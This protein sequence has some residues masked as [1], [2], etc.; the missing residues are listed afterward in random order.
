MSSKKNIDRLFQEK[1]KDFE[2]AP[3]NTVWERIKTQQQKK[4]RR[5]L[6]I[7]FWYKVVGIA[8]AVA[9][10]FTMM[11]SWSDNEQEIEIV[12]TTKNNLIENTSFR[13][14]NEDQKKNPLDERNV[15]DTVQYTHHNLEENKVK[16]DPENSSD[17]DIH[18]HPSKTKNIN[19]A[20][21]T[22]PH[23]NNQIPDTTLKHQSDYIH[24]KKD[25]NTLITQVIDDTA[26]QENNSKESIP[27]QN[28]TIVSK[29][30]TVDKVESDLNKKSIFEII[31]EKDE[32]I[33]EHTVIKG[34]KWNISPIV[35]PVYYD[36]QGN[37]SSVDSR[38]SD[39]GKIGELNLSYGVQ[40]AYQLNK[41]ISVRTGL[42]KVDLSYSTKDVGFSPSI[43]GQNLRNVNYNENSAAIYISDLSSTT[44]QPSTLSPD[45]NDEVIVTKQNEGILNHEFNYLEVPLELKYA[46][47]NKKLG[48]NMIGGVST[49]FLQGNALSITSGDFT[50][51][52]GKVNNLNTISFS[53]NLGLGLDYKFTD[54]FVLN[55][56]PILK[57]QFNA[58]DNNEGNFR[59][60]YF[61]M[62]TGVSFKF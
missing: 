21:T 2:I 4:K 8:A 12:D 43:S 58:I 27:N 62:Y 54:Q 57:Y 60:Y 39:N 1:F 56:E 35:G 37:G 7:P 5:V 42:S 46:L 47:S 15:N 28:T 59:P 53:G 16:F 40:L 13:K 45:I 14:S 31:E 30:T 20:N 41:K 33:A 50:T 61:G 44:R 3:D 26:Y 17:V 18:T 25:I 49:L 9:L 38:F 32:I 55:L 52:V 11:Y 29:D 23:K 10:L 34:K 48:V 19:L 36:H 51:K 6:I 22:T 24:P